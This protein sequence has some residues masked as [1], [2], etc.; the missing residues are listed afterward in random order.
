MPSF[1]DIDM[2]VIQTSGPKL[3]PNMSGKLNGTFALS[4]NITEPSSS[5]CLGGVLP[6]CTDEISSQEVIL[7]ANSLKNKMASGHVGLPTEFWKAICRE[8]TPADTPAC[9]WAKLHPFLRTSG[10][11]SEIILCAIFG[12]VPNR[13]FLADPPT[14]LLGHR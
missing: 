9:K 3:L 14:T 12:F 13:Q 6:V 8:D 10:P 2:L 4:L 7:A 1:W 11:F 5:C